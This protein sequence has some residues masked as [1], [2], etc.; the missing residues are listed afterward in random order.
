MYSVCKTETIAE[1]V[2]IAVAA[3]VDRPIL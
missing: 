1:H 2:S 3:T